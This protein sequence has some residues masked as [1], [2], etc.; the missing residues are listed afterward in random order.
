MLYLRIIKKFA[1]LLTEHQKNR[2]IILFFMMLLGA[3][4]EVCGVSLML[5]LVNAIMNENVVAENP[6]I[7]RICVLFHIKSH[8][9]FVMLCIVAM[10]ILYVVK[11]LY[12]V[13]ESYIQYRFIGNNQYAIQEKLLDAYLHR[14]YEFFLSAQSGE[15]IRIV[16]S[17][18]ESTFGMLGILLSAASETQLLE[19]K[20]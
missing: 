3:A 13:F 2:V 18:T 5:P 15:I 7:V 20:R 19:L 10:I 14:P 9:G 11:T 6:Y 16:Q 17:D 12:L 1:Q 4:F 8:T